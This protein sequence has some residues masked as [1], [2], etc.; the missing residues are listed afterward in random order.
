MKT[1]SIGSVAAVYETASNCEISRLWVDHTGLADLSCTLRAFLHSLDSE[2]EDEFWKRALGPV[3]RLAFTLCS[4]PL[5]FDLA[6]TATCIEWDKLH[7]QVQHCKQLYPDSHSS[8]NELAQKL[9]ALVQETRSPFTAPLESLHD[10]R[11]GMS[12][13]L[14]N[15]RM[16]QA[17]ADYFAASSRLRNATVVSARQLREVHLCDPLVVIGPC[18]WFPEY[19]FLAPRATHIHTLSFRWIR[20]SWKPGPVFLNS[21]ES[22]ADRSRKHYVGVLPQLKEQIAPSCQPLPEIQPLELLPSLP[23]FNN[24]ESHISRWQHSA[25][26]EILPSRLCLL[27]GG[28]AIFVSA[29]ESASLLVIDS[30]K[31]GN[32]IIR[33]VPAEKLEP[34]FFLLLRTSVG[35]DFIT[36]LA[37][38]ILGTLATKRRAQQADWKGRLV[39]TAQNQFGKLNR[40]ELAASVAG[41][42]RA[43]NLCEARPANVHYWMSSKCIH[44]RNK[45]DFATIMAYAGMADKTQELWE[46]MKDIGRAHVKAGQV[47]RKMLLQ[48]I[49]SSSLALLE[50]DGEMTFDLGEEDGGTLSAF[51]ITS[52]SENEFEI[53]ANRIGILM[54]LE[55]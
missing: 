47:I 5:P 35:G 12:V 17:T 37:D 38:R 28:R 44:P 3:R 32:S 46:A 41:L 25:N 48:K 50:R 49:A 9:R 7:Q 20:D 24:A 30:S 26:D 52:I 2:A 10:E 42:L 23:T 14:R 15:P 1:V 18:G 13:I 27:S 16:N 22:S 43:Q 19:V 40:R 6:A 53:P 45:N 55:E 31:T 39:A 34:E 8:F 11:G 33:R 36:P 4:T 29:D 21:G 54:D 51:L